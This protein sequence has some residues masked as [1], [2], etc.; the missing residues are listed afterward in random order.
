MTT[1]DFGIQGRSAHASA[2]TALAADDLLDTR[3]ALVI[4]PH[5]DDEVLGAG[6]TVARLS[7]AAPR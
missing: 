2:A 5:P 3:R 7:D 1:F 4:A 6:G